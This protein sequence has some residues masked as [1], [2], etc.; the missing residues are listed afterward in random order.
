MI[1]DKDKLH[2][3]DCTCVIR[4]KYTGEERLAEGTVARVPYK[5]NASKEAKQKYGKNMVYVI[6]R[7]SEDIVGFYQ[8]KRKPHRS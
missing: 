7:N 6:Y 3:G 4:N 8:E 5:K 1:K 2:L